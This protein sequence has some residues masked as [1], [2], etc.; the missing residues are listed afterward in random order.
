MT[1]WGFRT[2]KEAPYDHDHKE[3]AAIANIEWTQRM[4]TLV[5]RSDG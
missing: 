3:A 1:T 5:H 4:L 2:R